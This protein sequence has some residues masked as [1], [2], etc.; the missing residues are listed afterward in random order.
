MLEFIS[1]LLNRYQINLNANALNGAH[2]A[3]QQSLE[4]LILTQAFFLKGRHNANLPLQIAV[5]GPTQAGK[6]SLVNVLLQSFSAGVSP[7]AGYTVHP[8]GFCHA[9]DGNACETHL[10][11]YFS[12]FTRSVP[13]ELNKSNYACFS[14]T[15][16]DTTS[17]YLPPAVLWDTPDF[18]SIDSTV[19]REG[20]LKTIALADII[21]LIVSKEKYADQSVWDMM[22]CIEPLRQPTLICVNKLNEGSESVILQSLQEKWADTRRD[23]FAQVLP[24]FY[25]KNTQIPEITQSQQTILFELAK[26]VQREKQVYREQK[27]LQTHWLSWTAPLREEHV[28]YDAWYELV[29]EVIEQS[30]RHY[31]RDY[32]NHPRHYETFQQAIAELLL[33]LEIPSMARVMVKA[34]KVLLYP[35][36]KL[37]SMGQSRRDLSGNSHEMTV[38][39]QL[40]DHSLTELAH[41]LL[42]KNTHPLWRE[43]SLQLRNH[44]ATESKNSLHAA[45]AYHQAFQQDVQQ[46]AQGLYHKL[47]EQ[48]LVLNTLRATRVTADAAILA[49]T[50]YTGGIGLHDLIIAP[51]MLTLT[52]LLTE[53][54]IGSYM[55][56]VE[57]DLKAQQLAAVRMQIF[58]PLAQRLRDLPQQINSDTH[59]A[60][61]PKQLLDAEAQ[62]DGGKPHGL[63]LL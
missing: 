10:A 7:L 27:L 60:I 21:I 31:A 51:A 38:L 32:L 15:S 29:D 16:T 35:L 50:L 20:V 39:K 49:L 36:K 3:Y 22:K 56:K 6:S 44:H 25:Q 8:Q 30:L 43:M 26:K 17:P 63:R 13:K 9:L 19:Y 37:R 12:P 54:A 24:L 42:D 57:T 48:P 18:D 41:Q 46:A 14:F 62:L 61:S 34:R 47:E 58:D 52:N 11:A 4:Q 45:Q 33:L 5:I 1:L 2:R 53:S 40:I 28:I 23:A 59:F 55:R